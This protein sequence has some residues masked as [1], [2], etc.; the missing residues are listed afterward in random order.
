[1]GGGWVMVIEGSSWS[2]FAS[3]LLEVVGSP[4]KSPDPN[5]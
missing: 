5:N 2:L 3:I 1:M 4:A